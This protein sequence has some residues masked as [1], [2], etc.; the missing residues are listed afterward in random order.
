MKAWQAQRYGS[1]KD[2]LRLVDIPYPQATPG[3]LLIRVEASALNPID[4]KLLRGDLKR[5]EALRFP[6]TLG[7]DLAGTVEAIGSGVEGFQRGDRVYVRA[8][9][10]TLGAF[11][12]YSLQPAAF[13]AL[14]PR[15]LDFAEAA[16]FPLVALTT[17]QGVMDRAKAQAGQRILIHAGAGG[18]GSFA[19]QFCK[20][21]GLTVHATCSSGNADL[22]RSLGADQVIAYDRE[23]Y[24]Q[25]GRQYDIVFDLIGGV[26][27]VDAF[28]VV[29]PGGTVLSVSGPP[30]EDFIRKQGDSW[31]KRFVMRRMSAKVFRAARKA[32]AQYF[33]YLTESDGHALS[34]VT[35]LIEQG[36]IR[37]LIDQV[38]AFEDAVAAFE[39]QMSG[40]AK[41]KI[42]LRNRS[43]V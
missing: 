32:K 12:D 25:H 24:R 33:R 5:I 11:A 7:F 43:A 37:P 2:A 15:N 21:I 31:V 18:L 40:R 13:A 23:D 28:K 6:V 38:F 17:V 19:L 22:V 16:G 42:I 35:P 14:M 41:G 29:K 34:Q 26:H 1:P 10:N 20:A 3:N 4:F 8:S 30:D 36:R 39:R 9:R 27:T